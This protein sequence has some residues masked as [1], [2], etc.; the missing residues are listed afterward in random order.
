MMARIYQPTTT[1]IRRLATV[2]KRGGLVAVPSETVYGLAAHALDAAACQKIFEVKGRPPTDP[3]IVHVHSLAAAAAVAELTP[4]ARALGRAFWP[5][6]L[7]LVLKKKPVVPEVVTSG[8]DSVAVRIPQHRVFRD[9]LRTSGLPLAAP[10]AN[11]FGYVSPTTAGHVQDS[12]GERIEHI[13]DGGA[14][15]VG[16]ESTIVDLRNPA[17]PTVLRPGKITAEEIAAVLGVPVTV[18]RARA[19]PG[20]V[21]AKKGRTAA[22]RAPGMMERHYSPNTRLRW[23]KSIAGDEVLSSGRR[24]AFLF[25]ARPADPRLAALGGR[26]QWLSAAGDPEEAA[27]SLFSRL[28]ALDQGG[29]REIRV[30]RLPDDPAF[31]AVADRLNRAAARGR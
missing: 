15:A 4:A 25:L 23:V 10:S 3:L 11:P 1:T 13:L 28:R 19:H 26:V 29:Y 17:K 21:G 12:L 31:A 22:Q 16:V 8:L 20:K 2:L 27:R 30:Q 5:G 7:T 14:C 18:R 6:P 24:V 9:L